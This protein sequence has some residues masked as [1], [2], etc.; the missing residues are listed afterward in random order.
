MKIGM[1]LVLASTLACLGVTAIAAPH[2]NEPV[3]D[4]GLP[5]QVQN[6]KV[7]YSQAE[8]SN[9]LSQV[10]Q[11]VGESEPAN[12][13][14]IT[15]NAPS[16]NKLLDVFPLG[17]GIGSRGILTGDYNGD[18]K[19]D[20]VLG[21]PTDVVFGVY[22]NSG[23]TISDRVEVGKSIGNLEYFRDL[24]TDGHFAFVYYNNAIN[25]IDLISHK[26]IASLSIPAVSSYKVVPTSANSSMLLVRT[27]TNQLSI[28]DPTTLGVLAVQSGITADL[29]QIGAFTKKNTYQILFSDGRIFSLAN[30]ALTLE[31]TLSIQP[32]DLVQVLDR[33]DDGLDEIVWAKR[34]YQI[35]VYSP[36]TDELLF[37]HTADLNIDALTLADINKDGK[38]EIVYGDGQWGEL[39]AINPTNGQELWQIANPEHGVTNIAFADFDKDGNLDV[40]WG[41]GYTSSGADYLYVHDVM[42]KVKKWQSEDIV[43]PFNSNALADIDKDGDLD[44]LVLSSR[45]ESGYKGAVLQAFD[46][47]SKKRLYNVPAANNWGEKTWIVTG[48]VDGDKNLDVVIGATDIYDQF[49]RV[50]NGKTGTEKFSVKLGNGDDTSSLELVDVNNDG[51]AEIVVGNG[52]VHSGSLGSGLLVLDGK[53]GAVLKKSELLGMSWSGVTDIVSLASAGNSI[54]YAVYENGLYQFNYATNAVKKLTTASDIS[55]LTKVVVGGDEVLAASSG[56]NLLLLDTTGATVA[57]M[58]PCKNQTVINLAPAQVGSV[59]VNCGNRTL[60]FNVTSYEVTQSIDTLENNGSTPVFSQFAGHNYL[61]VGGYGV[62]VYQDKP[63]IQLPL[64]DVQKY[65][66]HVLKP[67]TG[68]FKIAAEVDF[69][70][71]K[72]ALQ[73]GRLTFTDRAKGTFSYQPNGKVGKEVVQV[74]AAKSG[75]VSEVADIT[76]DNT[77]IA[78]VA[79]HVTASTHWRTPVQLTLSAKDDDQETLSFAIASQPAH[80]TVKLVDANKGA[81][82]FTPSGNNIDKVSFNFTAKDS[83]TTTD[84]KTVT[85]TLTNSKP[86]ARDIDYSTSWQTPVNGLL[87]GEDVDGDALSYEISAQPTNGSVQLDSATGIF[88]YKATQDADQTVKFSYIAK[89]KFAASEPKTVTIGVQGSP[90]SD[91]GGSIGWVSVLMLSIVA[92]SRR[93]KRWPIA[94]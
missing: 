80:G 44:A 39:H 18:G 56:A 8:Y 72:N 59:A 70:S 68:Q 17:G 37:T 67:V 81:V 4:I 27:T 78:P 38:K 87:K 71:V 48:D 91:S 43:G 47:Q 54:M 32:F 22:E 69:F 16:M 75:V 21:N 15:S 86:V 29:V 83:L 9:A 64:P 92:A 6:E 35:V 36:N 41:A 49:V 52:A 63:A 62:A 34:W 82:E 77:N 23:L 53:T 55:N 85:I 5:V 20:V 26:V 13:N 28:V 65:A 94:C 42:S 61:L 25:K 11:H 84:V 88:V 90:K 19:V 7:N 14:Q 31:K 1:P 50:I 74:Y 33:D 51:A 89:D 79:E 40:T 57:S 12:L 30:N 60:L 66:T 3:N 46:I 2:K 58:T 45:S 73:Y 24:A 76:I 93:R 10:Q